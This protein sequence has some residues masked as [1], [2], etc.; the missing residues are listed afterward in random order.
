MA[1]TPSLPN[2]EQRLA[3]EQDVL[4]RE[5]DEAVRQ[6]EAAAFARRYGISIAVLLVLAL[7][8][9]GGWLWW[10]GHRESKLDKGSEQFVQAL[11][12]LDAGNRAAAETQLAPIAKNGTPAASAGARMLQAGILAQKGDTAGAAKAFMAIAD[13]SG[14]PEAYRN[15]AA[16]RGVAASFDSMKPQDV[17]NRLKPLAVPGNPW[18]GSAGELVAMGYLKQGKKDLAGPLF[19]SIAKDK[20]VPQSLQTRARQMAGILGYDAVTDVDQVLAAERRPAEPAGT[21]A[22]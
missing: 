14:A 12:Q 6:D 16:I 22:Q 11:D 4:M 9:F 17:I 21:P 3:A 5:V 13:D 19:A 7:A 8:A 1:L 20:D 2:K 15:L 10:Q 18:F